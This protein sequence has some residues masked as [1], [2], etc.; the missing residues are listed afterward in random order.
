MRVTQL[1][2][3]NGSFR[4][5]ILITIDLRGICNATQNETHFNTQ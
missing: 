5:S 2:R 4:G 3:G 1:Q